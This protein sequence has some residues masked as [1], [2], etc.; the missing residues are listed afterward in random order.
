MMLQEDGSRMNLLN[1]GILPQHCMASWPR[2]LRL[3]S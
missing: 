2:R 1:F 3:D